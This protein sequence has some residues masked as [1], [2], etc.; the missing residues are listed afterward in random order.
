MPTIRTIQ[1][2]DVQSLAD[3]FTEQDF[4]YFNNMY[5][6]HLQDKSIVYL[7]CKK[8]MR[9]KR[10]YFGYVRVVWESTY[11]QFWRRNIPE[12]TDLFV[13]PPYRKRGIATALISACEANIKDK[14]YQVVGISVIQEEDSGVLQSIYQ[15]L[16]Y[17]SDGFGLSEQDNQ[18]HFVK[19]LRRE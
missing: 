3:T 5:I 12:I 16:D 8:D 1:S 10:T 6:D 9:G 2:R 11:T 18:L 15:K 4:A 7:A 14:D 19:N 13:H 17:H